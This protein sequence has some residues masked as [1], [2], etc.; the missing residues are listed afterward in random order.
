MQIALHEGQKGLGLTSPN[1]AVGAVIVKDDHILG[2]GWHR[3]AGE[4]HA[5]IAA[6]DD[7][8]SRQSADD[9][10]GATLY[11]TL[12]PC[13]TEGKTGACTDAI[14]AHQFGRVVIGTIDPNP[15]HAGAGVE[16]LRQ[17]GISVAV[18]CREEE[19]R[20]L[21]RFFA[22][23]ITSGQPYVIAKS[24][25]TLDGRTVL[26]AEDGSWITGKAALDDVQA[27]R[28]QVDAI[29]VGGETVRRDNPRL[30]L[31]GETAKDRQQPWR[32]ILTATR[33]LP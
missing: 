7:A 5:E 31:R 3:R 6:I 1:P 8:L 13:S 27:L 2:K 12:E 16:I 19:A 22:K 17:A 30:T 24:A 26:R 9:L 14:L 11:V 29:L 15:D 4:A 18:G 33:D 20:H 23:H 10:K 21:I 25:I 28:R 32:V